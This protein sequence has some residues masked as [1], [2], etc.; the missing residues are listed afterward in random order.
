MEKEREK[1]TGRQLKRIKKHYRLRQEVSLI[2]LSGGKGS[3]SLFAKHPKHKT[4]SHRPRFLV[5][6]VIA[7]NIDVRKTTLPYERFN[8]F[9]LYYILTKNML[10]LKSYF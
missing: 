10:A 8:A 2:G 5:V 1:I 3:I 6:T 7:E 4:T 9:V